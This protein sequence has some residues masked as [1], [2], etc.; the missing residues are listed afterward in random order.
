MQTSAFEIINQ[1]DKEY[2][3]GSEKQDGKFRQDIAKGF[4]D[5][6]R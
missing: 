4:T 3:T 6:V 5:S 1:S 2:E